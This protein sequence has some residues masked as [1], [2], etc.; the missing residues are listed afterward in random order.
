MC[1]QS[2][3]LGKKCGVCFSSPTTPLGKGG[4][5]VFAYLAGQEP[6]ETPIENTNNTWKED[7]MCQPSLHEEARFHHLSPT[8]TV[9]L[10][11]GKIRFVVSRQLAASKRRS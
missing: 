2:L 10:V 6:R 9:G 8:S 1:L 7:R 11:L 3:C 4:K 5:I